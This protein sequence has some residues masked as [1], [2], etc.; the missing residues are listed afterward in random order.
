MRSSKLQLDNLYFDLELETKKGRKG[1]ATVAVGQTLD[2]TLDLCAAGEEN[3]LL[4]K[5][6]KCCGSFCSCLL[7]CIPRCCF[8]APKR[9][10]HAYHDYCGPEMQSMDDLAATPKNKR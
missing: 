4:L 6:I 10:Y 8:L 2:D 5:T 9:A 7:C 3:N 1:A